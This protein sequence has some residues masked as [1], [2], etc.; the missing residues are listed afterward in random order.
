V[1]GAAGASGNRAPR[2]PTMVATNS[3][4]ITMAVPSV[5]C[6]AVPAVISFAVPVAIS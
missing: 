5:I 2:M 6:L 4:T 3:V 1:D